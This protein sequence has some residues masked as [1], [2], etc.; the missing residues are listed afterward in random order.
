MKFVTHI[1]HPLVQH[2]LTRLRD[3]R[4][5]PEEFRRSLA[6]ATAL[7]ISEAT[8][9]FAV[10]R[11]GVTT[12][13][14]KTTGARLRREVLLVPLL[15]AG[16]GM[17]PAVMQIM[18]QARV[19]FVGL[20]RHETTLEAHTY[21]HSLPDDLRNFEVV[22]LDPMLATGG[23]ALAA[24][25]LLAERG[26]R[27]MRLVNI[28]VAPAGVRRVRRKFPRVPIFTAAVDRRLNERGYVVPGLG[29]AG[30]RLFG[31]GMI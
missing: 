22:I 2:S 25:T 1:R 31:V 16:L 17:L 9:S 13:L 29:D 5:E 27:R 11:V 7:L 3:R 18:P 10:E 4:T 6:V 28:L 19:G 26:A 24:L 12:P 14:A 20:K 23:S 30:D 21:H 15:R 8:R